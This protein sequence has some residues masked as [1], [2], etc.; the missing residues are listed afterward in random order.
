MSLCRSLSILFNL[1]RCTND[2][3]R[4][5]S[6]SLNLLNG[7]FGPNFLSP[8]SYLSR[9]SK[10]FPVLFPVGFLVVLSNDFSKDLAS[11][12]ENNLGSLAD[13][14]GFFSS[15][16]SDFLVRGDAGLELPAEGLAGLEEEIR[17]LLGLSLLFRSL[18]IF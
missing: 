9:V 13:F 11:D 14:D 18:L 10:D 1:L 8:F 17:G 16:S 5:S 2:F 7:F 6:F 12:G 15:E 3:A 4:S